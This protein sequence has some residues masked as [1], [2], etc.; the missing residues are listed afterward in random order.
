[1][2]LATCNEPW[3]D[4]PI[5]RV[6]HMAADLGYDGVEIAPFTLADNVADIPPDRRRQIARAAADAG[7]RIVGLKT[8]SSSKSAITT[9]LSIRVTTSCG[10]RNQ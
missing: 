9:P 2:K 4:T 3:K 8:S 1:M 7:V 5:E 10:R 6:F